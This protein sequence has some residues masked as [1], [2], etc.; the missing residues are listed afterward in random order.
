[1]KKFMFILGFSFLAGTALHAQ[2]IKDA[3]H[4]TKAYIK[5]EDNAQLLDK[6]K[7]LLCSFTQDG[8]ILS[9]DL[10]VIGY[11]MNEYELMDKDRKTVGF[12]LPDGTVQKADHSS[13]GHIAKNGYGAVVDNMN[14]TIGYIERIEPMW[15]AAYFFLLKY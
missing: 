9:P 14:H 11:I 7:N 5:F 10:R 6:N 12:I 2:E 3:N 13:L 4:Q 15:A 1:M 8:K